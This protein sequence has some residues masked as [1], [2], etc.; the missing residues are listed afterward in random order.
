MSSLLIAAHF[1]RN[2]MPVLAVLCLLV[3]LLLSIKKRW[4]PA[5]VIFF[6]LLYSIEWLRTLLDLLDRYNV[7]G[8]SS[9]RLTIILIAVILFNL[10][11]TGIFRTKLMRRRYS[12]EKN[13]YLWIARK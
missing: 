9:N 3:P 12:A 2:G 4:V 6:L 1:Y 5:V 8:E 10:L 13:D 11:S 7:A